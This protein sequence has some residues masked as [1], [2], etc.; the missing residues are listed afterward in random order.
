MSRENGAEEQE[1]YPDADLSREH[2]A[3][4]RTFLAWTRTGIAMIGF[5]VLIARLRLENGAGAPSTGLL[6]ALD[7]GLLLTIAGV[8]TVL[9]S[10]W[11]YY[12]VRRMLRE[13]RYES[14]VYGPLL[15]GSGVILVG[16]VVLLYLLERLP[17]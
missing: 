9:L 2:Q 17:F 3:N 13:R 7:L 11:R 15:F 14:W 6:R 8:L 1:V 4:E 12:V 10:M 5:G 16:V